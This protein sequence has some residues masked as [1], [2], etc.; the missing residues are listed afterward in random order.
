MCGR[1]LFNE[2]SCY[3]GKPESNQEELKGF[4]FV[5]KPENP[6]T[7]ERLVLGRN[8]D[9]L[10]SCFGVLLVC[11]VLGSVSLLLPHFGFKLKIVC[12]LLS[13]SVLYYYFC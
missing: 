2:Q 3:T 11:L 5:V 6:N 9:E 7:K 12:F 13:L 8:D 1:V 4:C 10:N